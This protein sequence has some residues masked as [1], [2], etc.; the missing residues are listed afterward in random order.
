LIGIGAGLN[1]DSGGNAGQQQGYMDFVHLH[2]VQLLKS[3]RLRQLKFLEKR[4][5]ERPGTAEEL[6]SDL[7]ADRIFL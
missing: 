7:F 6:F 2:D 1:A 5:L 4:G 3:M